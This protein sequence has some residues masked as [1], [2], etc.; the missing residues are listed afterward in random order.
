VGRSTQLPSTSNFQPWKAQRRPHSLVAA[1]IEVGAAVGTVRLDDADP[2]VGLA[3]RQ[4]VLAE[5]ADLLRRPVALGQFLREEGRHPEAPQQVT[6]RRVGPALRQES[7]FG[8]EHQ[9]P[10]P[11]WLPI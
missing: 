4:E 2:S 11:Y 9:S 10:N 5:E 6:H 3:E 1:V 8:C 7:V